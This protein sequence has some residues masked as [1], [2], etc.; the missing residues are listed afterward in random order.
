MIK[1]AKV[2]DKFI[3]DYE[4]KNPLTIKQKYAILNDM[5]SQAKLFG[6]FKLKNIMDGIE[7]KIELARIMNAII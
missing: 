1:N 2:F 6:H 5:Y 7:H 3:T 4:R